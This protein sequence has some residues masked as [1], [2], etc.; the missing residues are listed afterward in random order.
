M[1]QSG[2][3]TLARTHTLPPA[4]EAQ[5]AALDTNTSMACFLQG[6]CLD[7]DPYAARMRV[8]LLPGLSIVNAQVQA[9]SLPTPQRRRHR[10]SVW[11]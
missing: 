2:L 8:R 4:Q 3:T 7:H 10:A 11:V 1:L 9:V 5:G 6:T